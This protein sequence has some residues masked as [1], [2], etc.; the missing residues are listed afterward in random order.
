MEY[1]AFVEYVEFVELCGICGIS[2]KLMFS[3]R[4]GYLCVALRICCAGDSFSSERNK[5]SVGNGFLVIGRMFA[6]GYW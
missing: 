6:Q 4:K 5:T 1:V 2:L 3:K